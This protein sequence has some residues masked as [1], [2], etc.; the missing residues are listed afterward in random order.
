MIEIEYASFMLPMKR[1]ETG[2]WDDIIKPFKYDASLN[3]RTGIL[4]L[5]WLQKLQ[6][7]LNW[8][9]GVLVSFFLQQ[10]L[11]LTAIYGVNRGVDIA[12]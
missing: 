4:V 1:G 5:I 6:D 10:F 8:R 7:M 9:T 3:C 12:K 11:M 2:F